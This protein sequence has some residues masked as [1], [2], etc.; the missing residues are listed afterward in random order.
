[1]VNSSSLN[2]DYNVTGR[3]LVAGKEGRAAL[4]QL[5]TAQRADL[6]I[7]A[8]GDAEP[9]DEAPAVQDKSDALRS[10]QLL[11]MDT[12]SYEQWVCCFADALAVY[13]TSSALRACRKLAAR[14]ASFAEL[15]LPYLLWDLAAHDD[16]HTLRRRISRQVSPAWSQD[17]GAC[18]MLKMPS[19]WL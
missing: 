19:I 8:H 7:Y 5:N 4:A 6:G 18:R 15:L 16:D 3:R 12:G 2:I 1:M 17:T 9:A 13:A 14:Q 11:S 10:P